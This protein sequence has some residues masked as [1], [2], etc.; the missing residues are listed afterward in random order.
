VWRSQG[1]V[2]QPVQLNIR[3]GFKRRLHRD[4]VRATRRFLR[5]VAPVPRARSAVYIQIVVHNAGSALP[6]SCL[7]LWFGRCPD[8]HKQVTQRPCGPFSPSLFP[9]GSVG[10]GKVVHS[11]NAMARSLRAAQ[12]FQTAMHAVCPG[13]FSRSW[14][15]AKLPRSKRFYRAIGSAVERIAGTA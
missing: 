7:C 15:H 9:K 3:G 10:S 14:P 4:H 13:F 2:D 5:I 1:R 11:P 8:I 12:W 6:A